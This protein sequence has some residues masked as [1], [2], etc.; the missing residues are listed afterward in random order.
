MTRKLGQIYIAA[1]VAAGL[2]LYGAQKAE[3]TPVE[4]VESMPCKLSESQ[5]AHLTCAAE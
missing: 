5:G 1:I 4:I 3:P 2:W